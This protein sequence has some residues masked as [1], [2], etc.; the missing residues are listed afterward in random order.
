MMGGGLS[1]RMDR[2]DLYVADPCRLHRFGCN[3]RHLARAKLSLLWHSNEMR[4][5]YS[6]L[7][8]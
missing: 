8:Q 1:L 7:L 3:G 2:H 5:L 4:K 6:N